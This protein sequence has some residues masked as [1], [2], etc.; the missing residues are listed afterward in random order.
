MQF[1][2]ILVINLKERTDRWH[3]IS[4]HLDSL[5]LDYERVDAVPM[6]PGWKG[7]SLSFRKCYSIAKKRKYPWV[8]IL[9]DDCLFQKKGKERFEQ[10]L[11]LLW[12]RRA[13]WDIF[14]GG[15]FYMTRVCKIQENPPLFK[16]KAWSSQCILAHYNSYDRLIREIHRNLRVDKYFKDKVRAWCTFPHIAIQQKGYSDLDKRMKDTRKNFSMTDTILGGL[17]KN[18]ETCWTRRQMKRHIRKTRKK[19]RY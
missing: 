7:C 13:E 3:Q 17:L 2:P 11:P 19:L 15:S 9:E 14:N 1:P 18:K 6:E 16:L 5:G 12:Q 10:L 8:L 4:K